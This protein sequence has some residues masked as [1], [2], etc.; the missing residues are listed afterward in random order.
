M[1]MKKLIKGNA[2]K[3][4]KYKCGTCLAEEDRFV[5]YKTWIYCIKCGNKMW[6]KRGE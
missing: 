4:Y 3:T 6:L 5:K 2:L 1:W